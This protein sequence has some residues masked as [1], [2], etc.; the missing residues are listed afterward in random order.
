MSW[1]L[2]PILYRSIDT[3]LTRFAS[4]K[5]VCLCQ[6]CVCVCVCVFEKRGGSYICL[7]SSTGG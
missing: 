5:D 4:L 3:N 2:K 1:H 7:L 6:V